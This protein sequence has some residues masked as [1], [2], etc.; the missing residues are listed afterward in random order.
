MI[1]KYASDEAFA[2]HRAGSGLAGLVQSLKG[3][4]SSP[5]DVQVLTPRPAGSPV[6]GAL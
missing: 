3:K 5:I 4:L 1:E 2:V 6:K